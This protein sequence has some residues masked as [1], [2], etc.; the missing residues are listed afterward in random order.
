MN[1]KRIKYFFILFVFFNTT[2]Q[3]AQCSLLDAGEDTPVNCADTTADLEAKVFSGIGSSTETY[4]VIAADPC[5]LPP[6]TSTTPTDGN[7]RR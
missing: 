7:N 3:W 2:Y 5:P 6:S 4:E 1:F